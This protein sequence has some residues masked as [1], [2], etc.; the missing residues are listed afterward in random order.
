MKWN[1]TLTWFTLVFIFINLLFYLHSSSMNGGSSIIYIFIYPIFWLLTLFIVTFWSY[2]QR[3]IW[4]KKDIKTSTFILLFFCTPI[5]LFLFGALQRPEM[6][7]SGT[8]FNSINGITI[9]DETWNYNNGKTAIIKYYKINVENYMGNGDDDRF[10][11]DS[12]WIYFE[13]T[14]DTLKTETYKDDQLITTTK[15]Q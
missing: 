5:P 1:I 4:F 6:Y 13:K 14:G 2:K 8:G 9:K 11:K 12:T 3:D 7:R 10:K 15:K